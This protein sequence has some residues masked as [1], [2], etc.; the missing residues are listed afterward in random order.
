MVQSKATIFLAD[1]RTLNETAWYRSQHTF[2]LDKQQ[3]RFKEPFGNLY[4]L[5]DDILDGGKTLEMRAAEFSYVVLLP[6]IGALSFIDS[7]G[8]EGL[9]AAGQVEFLCLEKN[10]KLWITNPFK[11]ELVNFIQV[12]IKGSKPAKQAEAVNSTIDIN[13]FQNSLMKISPQR[14]GG[15]LSP[16][17]LSIGKF[18]GRGEAVYHLPG[19][20]AGVFVFVLEG[21][22]EVDGRLL[23]A[24]DGLAIYETE[25]IEMEAL[26][27]D[28]IIMLVE[29]PVILPVV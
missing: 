3:Q 26:S 2:N 21:A 25:E 23:H 4:I 12:W 14:I 10:G 27:R 8:Q 17:S 7:G 15:E 20:S 6:V 19:S 5:N 9:L 18:S 22:F 28:A 16:Y 29:L 24:R 13:K 1:D 11:D